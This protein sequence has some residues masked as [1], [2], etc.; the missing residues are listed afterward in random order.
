MIKNT[1]SEEKEEFPLSE[2]RG[3]D[4]LERCVGRDR[5]RP[6]EREKER[7]S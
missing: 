3:N 5:K 1:V 7:S 4:D 6:R 2:N